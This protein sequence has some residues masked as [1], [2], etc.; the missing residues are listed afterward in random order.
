MSH[1]IE[2]WIEELLNAGPGGSSMTEKQTRIF[3]A[4]IE[5]F[6][7]KG[8][9][10][11]STSE[12]AQRAGVA[13]GTIFRHYKT[14]K[15]LLI[16]IAAPAMVRLLA[17]FVLREFRTVLQTEFQSV[18]QFLRSMIENRIEFIEKNQ[19]LLKILLQEIPFHP[20][21]QKQ[22]QQ[23]VFSQVKDR[24]EKVI[25][26]FKEKGQII[27]LPSPTIMRLAVSSVM[28]YVLIRTFFGT[29]E[30]SAWDDELERQATIDFIMKGLTPNS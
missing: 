20:D 13:E 10:G 8:Y 5:V 28:G 19:S 7:E 4:A 27:D 21:L 16:S 3:E 15:D 25:D 17:P 29:R 11:S 26:R 23:L 9:S 18:D 22:F 2:P 6:A 24:I 14:K 30:G 12:I 1:P